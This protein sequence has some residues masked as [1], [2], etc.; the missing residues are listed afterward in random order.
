MA[1]PVKQ[2]EKTNKQEVK[3]KKAPVIKTRTKMDNSIEV[4]IQKS[5]AKTTLG[6]ILIYLIVAGTVLVPIIGLIM[7]MLKIK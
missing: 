3:S 6:K 5:P 7:A 1:K 2:K 4:E